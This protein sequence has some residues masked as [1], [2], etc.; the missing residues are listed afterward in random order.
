MDKETEGIKILPNLVE[1]HPQAPSPQLKS[2]GRRTPVKSW[3]WVA[4]WRPVP[5]PESGFHAGSPSMQTL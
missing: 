5:W 1:A 3:V 2:P 4:R